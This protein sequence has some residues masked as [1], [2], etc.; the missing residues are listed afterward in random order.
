MKRVDSAA[1]LVVLVTA[2][3][4]AEAQRIGQ[5]LL[6][7]RHAACVNIVPHVESAYQWQGKV[8]SATEVLLIAKTTA[9][10]LDAVIALVKRMHSYQVPEIIALPVIGGNPEYLAWIDRETGHEG[11]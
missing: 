6:N 5:T 1:H 11:A 8:E 2:S 7:E 10:Q 9:A 3:S 4:A